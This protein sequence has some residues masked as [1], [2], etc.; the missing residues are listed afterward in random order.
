[1]YYFPITKKFVISDIYAKGRPMQIQLP[2]NHFLPGDAVIL[3]KSL[4]IAQI[5][6]FELKTWCRVLNTA[7]NSIVL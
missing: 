2:V 7:L 5:V 3:K 6:L 4:I 1:M